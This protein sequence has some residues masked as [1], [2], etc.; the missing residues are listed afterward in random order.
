MTK[1]DV[2]PSTDAVQAVARTGA[3]RPG[4]RAAGRNWAPTAF[5]LPIAAVFVVLYAVPLAETIYYSFTDFNGFSTDVNLVGLANYRT[6]FTDP[7]LLTG[8]GFTLAF[9]LATTL[10]ITMLAIPLAVVLN[11]KFFGRSL[12]RSIFFFV[13]VPSQVILGL[14]WQYIFSPLNSGALNSVLAKFGM[15]PVSWLADP[16]IARGC[17]VFVAVWAGVGWHAM[18][19]LA[20][21]QAIPADL[22]EQSQVDGASGRQQFFHITLPQLVPAVVVSSFLLITGGLR[23]YELPFAM[24]KGG[25]GYATNTITQSII[26]R[27]LAQSDYGVGSA[28]AVLFTVACLAVIL[29]QLRLAGIVS[30]RFA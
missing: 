14:V 4:R 15:D 23:V 6:I 10:L 21:L 8:L 22:Y 29:V 1:V 27:G 13:G 11:K 12:V 2:P 26:L 9:A 7:S 30:K 17:V 19:Y 18:L 24:T 3:R 20:Y 25:P 28:L 16:Q 5:L